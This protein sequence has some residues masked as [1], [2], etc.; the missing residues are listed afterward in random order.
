MKRLESADEFHAWQLA[1][2]AACDDTKT[3]LHVCDGTGCRAL[4][5]QKVLART[6]KGNRRQ[7]LDL[8][9]QVV[10]TGC[11]GFCECGP[12]VTI[13]PE[14]ISYQK[15]KLEDVP[16]IVSRTLVSGEIIERLLYS[17]PLTGEH[18]HKEADLPFYR[19][20]VRSILD[21]NGLIDPTRDRDY[22][23]R[24][25][26]T[27]LAKVL[28][29]M[30]PRA[31]DRGGAPAGLRGRGGAGFPHR[32]KMG[33]LPGERGRPRA[34]DISFATPMRAIR[35]LLWT[36]PWLKATRTCSWKG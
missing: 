5:S 25:G 17:D 15:V 34:P 18:I 2:A 31:G 35:A 14:R 26:Y 32:H 1:L 24:G 30:T 6:S 19:K 11:P 4:G 12:L 16:E 28:Q 27:S 29:A 22:A 13:Y 9:I 36:A 3:S 7:E 10:G 21:L 23:A 33:A 8:S 20:Q